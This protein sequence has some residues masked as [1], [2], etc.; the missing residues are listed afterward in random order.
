MMAQDVIELCMCVCLC[1]LQRQKKAKNGS[2]VNDFY[3]HLHINISRS[4]FYFY[5]KKE[6]KIVYQYP[7]FHMDILSCF[8]YVYT[9]QTQIQLDVGITTIAS[10]YLLPFTSDARGMLL[11]RYYNEQHSIKYKENPHHNKRN[12]Y[13]LCPFR[14]KFHYALFFVFKSRAR[15]FTRKIFH[16]IF[17]LFIKFD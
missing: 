15:A 6:P 2:N 12:V 13:C 5:K 14:I 17:I 3:K 10:R 4:Q 7:Q 9:T 1:I 11:I 8:V 16:T